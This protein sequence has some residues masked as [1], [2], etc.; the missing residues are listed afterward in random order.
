MIDGKTYYYLYNVDE[1]II[2]T[3]SDGKTLC[4]LDTLDLI[5]LNFP[6]TVSMD[7]LSSTV[8]KLCDKC[9][10]YKEPKRKKATFETKAELV[11]PAKEE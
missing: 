1:K 11:D 8:Y 4:G 7:S 5:E 6:D 3:C 10:N 2:H 9:V